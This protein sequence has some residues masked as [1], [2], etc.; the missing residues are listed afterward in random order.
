MLNFLRKQMKW[1]MA[2][3]VVAF[4]LSTFFMYEGRSTR[5]SPSVNADGTMSDY[6][7]AKIN[8][9]SLMRS[10][11]ETRTRNYLSTLS[12]RNLASLDMAAIYQTVLNQAVLE[13]QLVK[14]IDDQGIKVSDAD[15]E[16]AM[17]VYADT[18][19][20]TRE[21]FY[22]ALANSGIKVE[23]YKRNL[24]RQIAVDQLMTNAIGEI[25]ISED[26]ALEFYDSMKNLFYTQPEG[27]M[28]H[29]ADFK[30]S[31]DAE[32]FRAKLVAGESW[33]VIASEDK[34]D[35]LVN[36]TKAP[37]FL[38]S[39]ALRLG[40]LSVLASLDISEPSE[41]FSVSSSDF[42][43]GL[44]AS[45]VDQ[46]TRPYGEVSGDIKA[47]LT[48][49]EQRKRL[50]DYEE[51]LRTKAQVVIN[52]EELF[53]SKK[54]SADE[55]AAPE[56]VIEDVKDEEVKPEEKSEKT[57]EP[58]NVEPVEEVKEETEAK[59]EEAKEEVKAEET[60]APVEVEAEKTEEVKEESPVVEAA[61]EVKAEEVKDET[62]TEEPKEENK[63]EAKPEA[64]AEPEVK[65]EAPAT[66]EVKAEEPEAKVEEAKTEV[67]EEIS[68]AANEIKNEVETAV[69]QVTESLD[70]AALEIPTETK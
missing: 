16:Q 42:A 41:V 12:T 39:S 17:K 65:Q 70:S 31:A 51:N 38:P 23:D 29:M 28:V 54:V 3:I 27:F 1:V 4:L 61:P 21:T 47:L 30:T 34:G 14:E 58:A 55:E 20:P 22:Q 60:P 37:V 35:E 43:V 33:D 40:T 13:S 18:Y 26:Q 49:E 24:A 67:K 62:P 8:G 68:E 2:I 59:P 15:A 46:S 52:D 11:L 44:K 45:H 10:E 19:Y 7:V 48:Q 6:E 57:E 53:T 5:R 63:E 9:R 32:A 69:E 56:I 50:A 66:E 64:E 25:D 36:I